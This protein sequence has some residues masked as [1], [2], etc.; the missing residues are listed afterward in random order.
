MLIKLFVNQ[1]DKVQSWGAW[2]TPQYLI[3]GQSCDC[4][5]RAVIKGA[6]S[7]VD[8]PV[9]CSRI[10]VLEMLHNIKLGVKFKFEIYIYVLQPLFLQCHKM[11]MKSCGRQE[12][13]L[14]RLIHF[15]Q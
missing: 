7:L 6:K 8:F 13:V 1:E 3:K 9:W 10:N 11:T 15:H 4:A 12:R 14:Q 2:R 5:P